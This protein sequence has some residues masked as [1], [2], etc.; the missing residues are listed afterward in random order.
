MRKKYQYDKNRNEKATWHQVEGIAEID[1]MLEAF[2]E[3]A[4]V[5]AGNG[6]L[7]TSDGRELAFFYFDTPEA[8]EAVFATAQFAFSHPMSEAGFHWDTVKIKDLSGLPSIAKLILS[9]KTGKEEVKLSI[10]FDLVKSYSMLKKV[11]DTQTIV[12]MPEK[13]TVDKTWVEIAQRCLGV[14]LQERQHLLTL[15][16]ALHELKDFVTPGKQH[17]FALKKEG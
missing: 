4:F 13:P 9:Y 3:G 14:H 12:L 1:Q 17:N 10:L 8:A 6:I 11:L 2:K 16:L 15:G 5:V 7:P